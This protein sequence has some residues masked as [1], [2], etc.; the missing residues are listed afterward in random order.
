[1]VV[2]GDT[3]FKYRNAYNGAWTSIC[4]NRSPDDVEVLSPECEPLGENEFFWPHPAY[5][6]KSISF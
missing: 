6:G 2:K 4:L 1:M 5:N 3:M